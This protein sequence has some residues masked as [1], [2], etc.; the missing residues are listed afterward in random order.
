VAVAIYT[1]GWQ[2]DHI[3]V[4]EVRL[5]SGAARMLGFADGLL[6]L[7]DLVRKRESKTVPPDTTESS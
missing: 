5:L 3:D 7:Y 6:G 1:V 2:I 4:R